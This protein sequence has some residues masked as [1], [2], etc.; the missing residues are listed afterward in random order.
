MTASLGVAQCDT[1]DGMN[2][3]ATFDPH[4]F[5]SMIAAQ[6][7][8]TTRMYAMITA[9]ENGMFDLTNEMIHEVLAEGPDASAT[10]IYNLIGSFNG[11]VAIVTRLTGKDPHEFVAALATGNVK[12]RE[13]GLE[14]VRQCEAGS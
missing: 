12:N 3:D 6:A 11:M 4:L 1:I 10:L 13:I 7:E 5:G 8:S 14:I 9:V 2:D